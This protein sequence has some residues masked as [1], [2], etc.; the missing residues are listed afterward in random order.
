L[1][2]LTRLLKPSVYVEVGVSAG[3]VFNAIVPFVPQA[4]A[5]D[6]NPMPLIPDRPNVK[7]YVMPSEEFA[8][9]WS[10]EID[11]LFIDADHR[12]EMVLKDFD[13]LAPFVKEGQG[14]IFLHDTHP[15][16][17]DLLSDDRCSNAW[18]AAW[19][20]RTHSRYKDFEIVTIPGPRAGLSILRKATKQLAWM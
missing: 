6:I 18:E 11:F 7:K 1:V 8:Q 5:V 13:L 17:P 4:V 3:Y 16:S 9:K 12:K 15:V 2:E 20:I 19:E 14:L 10:G